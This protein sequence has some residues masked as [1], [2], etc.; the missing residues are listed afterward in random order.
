VAAT[1]A[2]RVGK[3]GQLVW[4]GCALLVALAGCARSRGAALAVLT[5]GAALRRDDA[6]PATSPIFDGTRVRLRAA[7]GET[8]T[9]QLRT[10][11][12]AAVARLEL[13]E[14]VRVAAFALQWLNVR[15]PST[16]MYGP[17]RGAG[18]YADPLR[19][20]A[21]PVSGDALFDIAVPRDATPGLLHGSLTV[22]GRRLPVEL[23][24]ESADID[25]D[26]DPLV[27]I[28]YQP[29]EIALAH[30]VPDEDDRV[31]PLERQ[32]HAL[33]RAHGAYLASDLPLPR[34]LARAD[35]M[36]GV[37]YWPVTIDLSSDASARADVEQWLNQFA[38]RPQV[39]FT[40][41]VDEPH[42]AAE[43][44]ETRRAGERIG[45]HDKL[46]RA[47][48]AAPTP[49][50]EGA[51]DVFIGA[52]TRSPHRWTYNGTPP[53]AGNMVIDAAAPGLR[54]WGWIA[55]RYQIELWYA[56][57]GTYFADRYNGAGPTDVLRQPLTFDQR[58]HH[59]RDPDWGNGDGVLFYPGSRPGP[60]GP[61]PSLRL[62]QLRRGLQ[63]RLLLQALVRCGAGEAAASEARALV[64]RA[65]AGGRDAAAWPSDDD[66]WEAARGRLYDLLRARCATVR[67]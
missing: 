27:W 13:P 8:V 45:R 25:L 1:W 65:L 28:W 57:E 21:Q 67:P 63:D 7:R 56:W 22:D 5:E 16:A 30:H 23:T 37:R 12:H 61:W 40:I 2:S 49:D 20:S 26:A 11:S 46:L 53:V 60:E 62:K 14:P 48:T 34:F 51:M 55:E 50:L 19:P 9:L 10:R 35:L 41:P 32:Y 38:D 44:A 6:L 31:L 33:A 29:R 17:S 54:T 47:V 3:A 39:A 4:A 43:R 24:V 42:T 52:A 66:A 64:P 15:E 59:Q 58:R 36:R 18:V